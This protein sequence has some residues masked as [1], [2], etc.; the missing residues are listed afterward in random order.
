MEGVFPLRFLFFGAALA[1]KR[2]RA[3]ASAPLPQP[4]QKRRG[5]GTPAPAALAGTQGWGAK[6]FF[7]T[8]HLGSKFGSRRAR[9]TK[10][11]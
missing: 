4:A 2:Q 3:Q 1:K 5:P 8:G 9:G 6:A 7:S 10:A 11:F